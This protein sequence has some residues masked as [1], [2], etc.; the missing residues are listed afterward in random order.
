MAEVQR[1]LSSDIPQFYVPM[2]KDR[3]SYDPKRKPVGLTEKR[4]SKTKMENH[5]AVSELQKLLVSTVQSR[6]P[7]ATSPFIVVIASVL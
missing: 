6:L 2:Q 5:N 1:R 7:A 4:V 3:I